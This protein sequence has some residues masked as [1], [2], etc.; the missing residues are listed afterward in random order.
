[1]STVSSP[2][3]GPAIQVQT[4]RSPLLLNAAF[5]GANGLLLILASPMVAAWLGPQATWIYELVGV[6]LLLFGL[7]LSIV[8]VRPTPLAVLAITGADVAWVVSTTVTLL[9]WRHDFTSLGWGLVL[10]TNAVV[11]VLAWFQQRSIRTAFQAPSG[12]PDE[13]QVCIAVN[14]PVA[15]D[16]FWSVLADLGAIQ[17]YMPALKSSALTVGETSG[18][19]CVRTCENIKGQVWSEECDQWDEGRSFSVTFL[20][21]AHGFPFPFSKMRGGWRVAPNATGCRVEVWWQV[22]PR[23]PATAAVVLPLMAAGAQRSFA[24]VV[25][26]MAGVAQGR[27]IDSGTLSALPRFHAVLC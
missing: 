27:T 2:T 16:A 17:R 7:T 11:S 15:A 21:D 9:V 12:A 24:G 10:A 25:E 5:S 6:G 3:G 1:M 4:L 20:T 13:Y 19:G 8:A 18:V 26:R 14:T 23:R 22:V